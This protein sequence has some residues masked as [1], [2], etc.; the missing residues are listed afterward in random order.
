MFVPM[1]NIKKRSKCKFKPFRDEERI[2]PPPL[3]SLREVVDVPSRPVSYVDR[4]PQAAPECLSTC[5]QPPL[6][7]TIH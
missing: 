5:T 1:I 3:P 2:P 4:R 6:I 7:H